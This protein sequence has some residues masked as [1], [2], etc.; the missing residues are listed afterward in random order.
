MTQSFI[1]TTSRERLGCRDESERARGSRKDRL[2]RWAIR[3]ESGL[4]LG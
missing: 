4:E 1:A 2:I 3:A